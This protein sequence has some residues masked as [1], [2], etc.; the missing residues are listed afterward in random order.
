[1]KDHAFFS[2]KSVDSAGHA[3]ALPVVD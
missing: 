1:L 2:R 3:L